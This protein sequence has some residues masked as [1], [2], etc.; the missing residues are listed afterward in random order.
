[1]C[2]YKPKDPPAHLVTHGPAKS[3]ARPKVAISATS[4]ATLPMLDE[5]QRAH[6]G[7]K[8]DNSSNDTLGSGGRSGRSTPSYPPSAPDGNC[9]SGNGSK[10]TSETAAQGVY[11]VYMKTAAGRRFAANV[12][13]KGIGTT[14]ELLWGL[15]AAYAHYTME[16]PPPIGAFAAAVV[17]PGGGHTYLQEDIPASLPPLHF[18]LPCSHILIQAYRCTA[19]V[20]DVTCVTCVR[21]VTPLLPH[22]LIQA[23]TP[24]HT[25]HTLCALRACSHIL[26]H[27]PTTRRPQRPP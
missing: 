17:Q 11:M 10:L 13:V 3:S 6:S 15:R 7:G 23:Y 25:P 1:M 27:R 24:L 22:L 8:A 26:I 5:Q 4:E 21:C 9:G 14:G 16:D 19:D 18:L 12:D 2:G 20:T